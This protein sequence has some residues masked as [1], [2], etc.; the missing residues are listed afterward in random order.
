MRRVLITGVSGFIG[1]HL[2]EHLLEGNIEVHGTIH[3]NADKENIQNIKDDLERYECDIRDRS[4][5]EEII[6]EVEPDTIFHLAAQA[7]LIPSWENPVHTMNVNVNGTINLLESAKGLEMDPTIIVACSSAA[8][9]DSAREHIPLDE[10]APL[11]PLSPYAVSKATAELLCYQY[12][13]NFN[14]KAIRARIFGT[15]G[16][17]KKG[18]V[19]ADFSNQIAKMEA[20]LQ[21]PVLSTG[22]LD[23]KRDITDVRDAVRALHLLSGEGEPGE[24]YNVCSGQAYEIRKILDELRKLTN[25]AFDT[26][27]DPQKMRIEDEPI[28]LGDNSKIKEKCG[29]EPEISIEDTLEDIL[30]YWRKKFE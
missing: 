23:P 22:N 14:L 26:D 30:E 8:Y 19:C 7:Y 18:D 12:Y 21:E 1:S 2:A 28:I 10:D 6:E 27:Q 16:P 4:R 29:W 24:A 11:L 25:V 17:R 3:A 20:G 13:R 5:V 15:T 9:G